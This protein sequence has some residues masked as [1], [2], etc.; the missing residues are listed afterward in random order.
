MRRWV[1]LSAS[2]AAATIAAAAFG[3][4]AGRLY[5]T[6][7]KVK[8]V[9]KTQDGSSL[10]FEAPAGISLMRAI[11]DVAKLEMEGS[12]DGCMQCSTCHVYLSDASYKN[13][14]EPSEQE[15]DILD[16]ALEVK[17]TSRLACQILLTPETDGIEVKLPKNVV[18]L[19]M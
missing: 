8:V 12:C 14:G 15:Q 11:R 10:N 19:L 18:N 9:V 7:G 6:P 4:P 1:S 2:R 13:L 3:G 5:S 17:D 16:K